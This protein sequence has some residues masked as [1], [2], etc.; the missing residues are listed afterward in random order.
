ML[1]YTPT[2][3]EGCTVNVIHA[4][5]ANTA[6]LFSLIAGIWGVVTYIRG[7][8]VGGSYWGILAIAEI[9]FVAEGIMGGL[10]WLGGA[11]PLRPAI[12]ILYGA[13]A[14]LTLPFYYALSKG[15]ED[16]AAALIYGVLCLFLTGISLR[17]MVT[18]G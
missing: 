2:R 10:L 17:S 12:H 5:L 1:Q 11:R 7:R 13:V 6:F 18:G 16:R 14:I 8:G 4:N 3:I 9:L 15:R